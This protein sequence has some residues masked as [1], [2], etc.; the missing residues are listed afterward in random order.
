MLFKHDVDDIKTID[1]LAEPDK[2]ILSYSVYKND[3]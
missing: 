3:K 1:K 2:R